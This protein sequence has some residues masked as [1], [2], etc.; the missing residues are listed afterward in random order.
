MLVETRPAKKGTTGLPIPDKR[1]TQGLNQRVIVVQGA[2]E[3]R[4]AFAVGCA[5]RAS[6]AA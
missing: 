5:A 4:R 6:A 1:S 3:S 2:D